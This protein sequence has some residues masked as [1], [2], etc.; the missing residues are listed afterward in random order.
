MCKLLYFSIRCN[1]SQCS[2]ILFVPVVLL[3]SFP[4]WVHDHRVQHRQ[5]GGTS[6]RM[7]ELAMGDLQVHNRR[8]QQMGH[9]L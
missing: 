4:R 2:V 3:C 6:G 8:R 7:S 1:P 9:D 5:S